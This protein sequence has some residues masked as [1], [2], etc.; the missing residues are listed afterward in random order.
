MTTEV[1]ASRIDKAADRSRMVT[2]SKSAVFARFFLLGA[3]LLLI[4]LG[5]QAYF[6]YLHFSP[7]LS[8]AHERLQ[9]L[10]AEQSRPELRREVVR[11]LDELAVAEPADETEEAIGDWAVDTRD[12][13]LR[14][15]SGSPQD[16]LDD[17]RVALGDFEASWPDRT[18]EL[19][20][21]HTSSERLEKVYQD[22]YENLS[23]AIGRPPAHLWPTAVVLAESS[24][25]SE[26]ITFNRALYLAQTGEFGTARVIL[27][28]LHSRTD[29][30]TLLG[31]IY[32]GLARLQFELFRSQG[33]SENYLQALQ[34]LRESL[35]ADQENGLA[36]RLLDYLLS[37]SEAETIPRP[38]DGN[39]TNPTEGET[40]AVSRGKPLF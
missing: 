4:V 24:G 15:F 1:G 2:R 35:Q 40:G 12:S 21:V 33:E 31:Q 39:P 18:A 27:T 29:D 28:G 11:R 36:S 17:L 3:G 6:F 19:S 20:Q 38:G 14:I 10:A 5:A 9:A 16:A 37:L 13:F 32:Y 8:L 22:P 23:R 34:Y 25:Y 30:E 26:A 7:R